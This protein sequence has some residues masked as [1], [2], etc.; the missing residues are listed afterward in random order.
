MQEEIKLLIQA[1]ESLQ[2][3]S[4]PFKDYV[5]PIITGFFSAI[6]GALVAYFTLRHQDNIQLEKER[7]NTVNDWLL[8]AEGAISSLVAIKSNY[9]GKLNDNPFQR[10]LQTRSLIHSTKKLDKN[11]SSLSFVIPKKEDKKAQTIKWRQLPRIRAMIENY[12]FIIELWDKR[13]EIE[14]P[15]K[16]QIIKDYTDLAYTEVTRDQ[17][18]QS[19]NP[20]DFIVL[21]DLTERAIKFTDD[22]IIE[23][24]D[25]MTEFP[26]IGKSLIKD[27]YIKQ[28]GPI[29]T[30]T[31]KHRH[32]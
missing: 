15:I 1:I 31:N 32:P 21:I 10:T 18:F 27:K 29:I 8:L 12:N 20:S 3:E 30:Y 9:H 17:I 24:D 19:V 23:L 7:I 25:F 2:Q 16:E 22:L 5:F 13:S 14:R 4:N 6:L 11:L 26:N 28:Y